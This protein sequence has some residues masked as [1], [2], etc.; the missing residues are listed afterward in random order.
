M[1]FYFLELSY[2]TCVT[3]EAIEGTDYV[4]GLAEIKKRLLNPL[5]LQIIIL[6]KVS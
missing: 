5:L 6:F 2:L 3:L 1:S 4:M